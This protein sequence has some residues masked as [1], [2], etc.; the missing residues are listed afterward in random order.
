[1]TKN[2]K[3]QIERANKELNKRDVKERSDL[4]KRELKRIEKKIKYARKINKRHARR[5]TY[6]QLDINEK[7]IDTIYNMLSTKFQVEIDYQFN[8]IK[9][10]F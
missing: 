5:V 2:I 1:M 6:I 4:I 10:Y 8:D 3:K 9:L 7:V